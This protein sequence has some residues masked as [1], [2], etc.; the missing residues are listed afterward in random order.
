MSK[1]K[2]KSKSA[3]KGEWKTKTLAEVTTS[4]GVKW[5]A[6]LSIAPDKTKFAGIRKIAVKKDGTEIVTRDGLTF[7]YDASTIG[8]EVDA[9][10]GL[11]QALKG[12]KIKVKTTSKSVVL[13]SPKGDYLIGVRVDAHGKRQ[14][15]VKVIHT[16][17]GPWK[18][19]VQPERLVFDDAAAAKAFREK[20]DLDEANW[21]VRKLSNCSE[22]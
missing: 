14:S 15:G 9:I 12:G 2:A 22:T 18:S 8:D 19:K 16:G 4:E 1:S 7:K 17:Q 11:L 13:V 20:H 5:R 21:R 6:Q 3:D 10:T